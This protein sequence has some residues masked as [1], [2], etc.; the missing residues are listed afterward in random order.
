MTRWWRSKTRIPSLKGVLSENYAR[1]E[2]DQ[3]RLG[4]VIKLFSDLAFQDEHHGQDVLGQVYEYFLG[5]FAI[6][7]GKRG[8]QFY[9]AGSVVR[10]LVA[11]L[12]P[13]KGRVY[14]P[15]CGC[16]TRSRC[17]VSLGGLGLPILC[18][19][20]LPLAR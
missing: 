15:C 4:E 3:I 14:D 13:F 16:S 19:S 12:Q 1:P 11:M 18:G 20:S 2:L 10:L 6:A 8:G 9:T 17:A 7:E 5:Q